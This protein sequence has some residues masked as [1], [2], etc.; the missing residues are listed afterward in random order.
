MEEGTMATQNVNFDDEQLKEMQE[1]GIYNPKAY[2]TFSRAVRRGLDLLI[3][4]EKTLI[5]AGWVNVTARE[6][7]ATEVC[8]QMPTD[9]AKLRA[10]LNMAMALLDR[11]RAEGE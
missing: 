3:E 2:G 9:N 6:L 11:E 5:T 4:R 10:V 8:T 1:L 7:L